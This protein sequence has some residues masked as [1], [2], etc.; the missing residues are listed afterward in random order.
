MTILSTGLYGFQIENLFI[1]TGEGRNGKGLI[2]GLVLVMLGEYGYVLPSHVLME[3]IKTGANPAD[4]K[5]E[6]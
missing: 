6:G 1:A 2:N 4:C 3:L 5:N